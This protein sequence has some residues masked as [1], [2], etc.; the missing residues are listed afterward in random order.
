MKPVPRS[1]NLALAG[2]FKHPLKEVTAF[3]SA[4]GLGVSTPVPRGF[5]IAG[6]YHHK[7]SF[8]SLHQNLFY[9]ALFRGNC[10][11]I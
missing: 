8:S 9:L 11:P 10:P 3:L 6:R 1:V 7:A 4:E 5:V 2:L